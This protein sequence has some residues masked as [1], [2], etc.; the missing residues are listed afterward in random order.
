METPYV[1]VRRCVDCYLF[2]GKHETIYIYNEKI[3][4]IGNQLRFLVYNI[5]YI[6][7]NKAGVDW[8]CNGRTGRCTEVLIIG[9]TD[10]KCEMVDH[11]R[12]D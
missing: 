7:K 1:V 9:C 10:E 11:F 8:G 3:K 6:S 4:L 5:E 2:G 12:R